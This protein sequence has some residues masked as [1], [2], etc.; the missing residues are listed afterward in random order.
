MEVRFEMLIGD[1]FEDEWDERPRHKAD[2][3]K[4]YKDAVYSNHSKDDAQ[5]LQLLKSNYSNL[6]IA[7]NQFSNGDH[8][9]RGISLPNNAVMVDPTKAI[10]T[11]ANTSNFTNMLVSEILPSWKGWPP[12]NQALICSTSWNTARGYGAESYAKGPHVV[13]P[14]GDPVIGICSGPD[15]WDSFGKLYPPSLN[16]ML[17]HIIPD[18]LKRPTASTPAGLAKDLGDLGVYMVAHPGTREEIIENWGTEYKEAI[19]APNLVHGFSQLLE[20]NKNGFR[21]MK[22][23]ELKGH[24]AGA[25]REVWVSAPSL[26]VRREIVYNFLDNLASIQL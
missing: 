7:L 17:E 24:F 11:A 8:I 16:D 6:V 1:L 13:L 19:M 5:A 26:L 22:L 21:R 9:Y 25:E 15:F 14:L 2:L 12:R 3:N 10:R 4:A 23:S 18:Y 20:P